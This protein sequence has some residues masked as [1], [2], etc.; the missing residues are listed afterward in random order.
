MNLESRKAGKE[1]I[2]EREGGHPNSTVPT[3]TPGGL[4][5][6]FLFSYF[7]DSRD[8]KHF[9]PDFHPNYA[10]RNPGF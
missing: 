6:C 4:L 10:W 3:K 9:W 5:V 8:F 1:S 7:P 2:D